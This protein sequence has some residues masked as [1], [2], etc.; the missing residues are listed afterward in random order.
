MYPAA[1]RYDMHGAFFLPVFLSDGGGVFTPAGTPVYCAA[2]RGKRLHTGLCGMSEELSGSCKD[3][4]GQL[5]VRGMYPVWKVHG[6][7]PERKYQNVF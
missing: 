6:G 1:G 4:G 2:Q 7:L 5:T 3:W